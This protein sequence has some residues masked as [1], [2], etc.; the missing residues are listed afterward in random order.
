MGDAIVQRSRSPAFSPSSRDRKRVTIRPLLRVLAVVMCASACRAD[1]PPSTRRPD[2]LPVQGL[3]RA[4]VTSITERRRWLVDTPG[5]W[6]AVWETMP[7]ADKRG[8]VF[9]PVDFARY[10]VVVAS[11]GPGSSGNPEIV[12]DGY[13]IHGDTMDV[14]LRETSPGPGCGAADDVTALVVAARVPRGARTV[15]LIERHQFDC[16]G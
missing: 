14:H 1:D 6:R 10:R 13:A 3:L 15:R 7:E 2:L 11:A 4:E 5:E 16:G 12:F 8:R 9:P